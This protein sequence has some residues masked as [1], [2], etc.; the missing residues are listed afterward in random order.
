M[1]TPSRRFS[2]LDGMF[3]VAASAIGFAVMRSYSLEV[4]HNNLTPYPALPRALL[5][6]W[7]YA[8]ATMPIPAVWAVV[9]FACRLRRP[10]PP[11]RRLV[12]QPG[13]V[14][15]GAVSLVIAI[16][17]TGFLTLVART[18]GNPFYTT[19]LGVSEA[20]SVTISY[21]GPV[22]IATIYNSAYFAASAFGMST[23]VAAVWLLLVASGRWRP[24]PSWLDRL[25]RAVGAYWI[26]M[27]P[28][29]CWWDYHMLY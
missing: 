14:A 20:L 18:L 10:R 13:F 25:G 28:L 21:P 2:V 17:L 9:L 29:S 22:N 5:T 1:G 11:W 16:R 3:L 24:E 6:A 12:N 8:I 23:S 27:I 26:A 7:A 19:N 15:C 4:L